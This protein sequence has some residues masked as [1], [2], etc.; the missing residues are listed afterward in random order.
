[1]SSQSC[2]VRRTTFLPPSSEYERPAFV[3]E[4]LRFEQ[5]FRQRRTVDGHERPVFARRGL[6]D[7]PRHH[8]FPRPRFALQEDGGVRGSYAQR[9][10]QH[11]LPRLGSADHSTPA[12]HGV[13]PVG[14]R[15]HPRVESP[16]TSTRLGPIAFCRRQLLVRHGH[17]HI[18]RDV[19]R[20]R[21][22][23]RLSAL[24]Q[25]GRDTRLMSAD[26]AAIRILSVD[27]HP[28]LREGVAQLEAPVKI[29]VFKLRRLGV[30]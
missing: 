25:E 22:I 9:L 4:E 3:P 8:F 16:G 5:L 26:Q 10:C 28:L 18:V 7:E 27:D 12:G 17:R 11:A 14:E 23:R 29:I 6:V 1:V 24:P 15:P 13:A 21:D 19:L 2:L 30:G 20:R